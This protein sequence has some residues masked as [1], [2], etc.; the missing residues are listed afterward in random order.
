M[1]PFTERLAQRIKDPQPDT[2][3]DSL[4][5]AG[6]TM[7]MWC[8]FNGDPGGTAVVGPFSEHALPLTITAP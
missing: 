3:A 2:I 1:H 7:H 6:E 8:F 5:E 4:G